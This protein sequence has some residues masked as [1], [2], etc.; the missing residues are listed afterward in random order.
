M[1]PTGVT[2]VGAPPAMRRPIQWTAPRKRPT[3]PPVERDCH[4]DRIGRHLAAI[5]SQSARPGCPRVR[6]RHVDMVIP[7]PCTTCDGW[8]NVV[9]PGGK[10]LL[11]C[12]DCT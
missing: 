9:G 12:P 7:R 4:T 10:G 2:R 1:H 5:T 11:P 8:G 6:D 3:I